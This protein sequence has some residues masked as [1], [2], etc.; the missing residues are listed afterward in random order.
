M[1]LPGKMTSFLLVLWVLVC[2]FVIDLCYGSMV[3]CGF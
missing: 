1:T 2:Y 3:D